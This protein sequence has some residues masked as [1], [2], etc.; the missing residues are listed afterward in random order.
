MYPTIKSGDHIFATKFSYG[1]PL[2]F[3]DLKLFRSEVNRGDIVIFPFPKDPSDDYIKRVVGRGGDT[4][5]VRETPKGPQPAQLVIN[6][7]PIKEPYVYF[8]PEI[9]NKARMM[10][11]LPFGPITVPKGR[12]FVMGDNR[13][14]SSDGRVWGF[15]KENTV[16]GRGWIIFFSHDPEQGIF[17][18]YRL[19]RFA[20]VLK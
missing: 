12:L 17:S 4:I 8:D 2:P 18:G 19:E 7:E 20:R 10:G 5:E 13:L 11:E 1:I 3:T 15:V 16:I 9:L 6:G 14:N